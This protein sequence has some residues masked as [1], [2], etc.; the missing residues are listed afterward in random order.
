MREA[1]DPLRWVQIK[2]FGLLVDDRPSKKIERVV[3]LKDFLGDMKETLEEVERRI[4]ELDLKEEQ[5]KEV[6]L[7]SLSSNMKE[8]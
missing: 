2:S 6:V 8:M 1:D 7:E 3:N 4:V 5:L